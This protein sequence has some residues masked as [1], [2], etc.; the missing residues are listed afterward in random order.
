MSRL[1]ILHVTPY[2]EQAWAYGGIPRVVAALARGQ[3]RRGH[4]VTVCASDACEA[5]LR[6]PPP[7]GG[8][9][10]GAW[11]VAR[12]GDGRLEV[13]IFTNLS[14]T[15]AYQAQFFLPVGLDRYLREHAG[16]FDVAH[17][18]GC[19]NVPGALAAR[20]LRRA[21]VPY[22][23]ATH[24]TAPRIERRIVAKW[25]FDHT[26]GRHVLPWASRLLAVTDAER[27]QL[28]SLGLRPSAIRVLPHPIDLSESAGV[29]S[30]SFRRRFGIAWKEIV[31]YLGKLTPRKGLDV[32]VRAF[33]SLRR[34]SAGLVI[35]GNNMG[36]GADVER[37]VDQHGLRDRTLFTGLLR[38][39]ERLEALA[40]ASVVAL[41]S[42]HEVFGLVP[43]EALL[44]ATPVVVSDDSGCGEVI[45]QIG[46]GRVV[47]QG[48]SGELS[49]AIGAMLDEPAHW[50]ER[51]AE[52]GQ[53]V[54][55][56][57]GG[58][59]VFERLD[60]LYQEMREDPEAKK[61]VV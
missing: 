6:L 37:L 4:D 19:H 24:G 36:V 54:R 33:S 15:L 14:N 56:A 29:P 58:D 53:R 18:H 22:L 25:I 50:R 2:Y 47:A 42:R 23:L 43:I 40:D 16:D 21:G 51:A 28:V 10:I 5:H 31:L 41:P 17:L 34:P 13:R 26:V 45:G 48:D 52:A 12:S 8:R 9:P 27:M 39:R 59:Q 38:G 30:G 44:C 46:G 7:D 49:D 32:L 57:W 35:A 1:R 11:P 55:E 60:Q 3:S 20:H 61:G